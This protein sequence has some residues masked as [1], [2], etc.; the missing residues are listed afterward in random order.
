MNWRRNAV[1][2]LLGGFVTCIYN[3][4]VIWGSGWYGWRFASLSI[5]TGV[6]LVGLAVFSADGVE[7]YLLEKFDKKRGTKEVE[8]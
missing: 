5:L 1:A 6:L 7:L 8:K 4:T 3:I 2:M